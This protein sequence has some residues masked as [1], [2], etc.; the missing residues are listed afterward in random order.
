MQDEDSGNRGLDSDQLQ[1][2][3][4]GNSEKQEQG[5]AHMA[6]E[7]DRRQRQPT[8]QGGRRGQ[9]RMQRGHNPFNQGQDVA[10]DTEQE[11]DDD[12]TEEEEDDVELEPPGA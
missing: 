1:F 9:Q 8:A 2:D 11:D 6:V 5:E 4:A 3:N 10:E 12:P 7:D